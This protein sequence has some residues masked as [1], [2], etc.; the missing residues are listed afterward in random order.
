MND[1][2]P[3]KGNEI[4]YLDSSNWP[5]QPS[6]L[7]KQNLISFFTKSSDVA[8][9]RL[10]LVDLDALATDFAGIAE[11]NLHYAEIHNTIALIGGASASLV[12]G[13]TVT[14]ISA[15]II[16]L[17]SILQLALPTASIALAMGIFGLWKK[18]KHKQLATNANVH[19]K[20]TKNFCN[21]LRESL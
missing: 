20:N 9:K 7:R 14:I 8:K 16:N 3:V 2:I 13:S 6:R 21:E 12:L 5:V 4:D 1:L 18:Y 19:A 17:V 11:K 10:I 15:Q